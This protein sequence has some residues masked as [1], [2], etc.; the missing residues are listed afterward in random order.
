M[1]D[2]L[3]VPEDRPG[4]QVGD[5]QQFGLP[6]PPWGFSYATLD[7]VPGQPELLY[8]TVPL[9]SVCLL[10]AVLPMATALR[11]RKARKQRRG[12]CPACGYDL[13]ASPDHCPE[14]GAA[15]VEE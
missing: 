12:L 15:A 4:H 11:W 2:Y 7:R 3:F 10:A 1:G 13:R 6:R 9:G 14:C 8:V 5:A